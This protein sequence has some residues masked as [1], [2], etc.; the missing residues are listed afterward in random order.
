MSRYQLKDKCM[1]VDAYVYDEQNRKPGAK[2]PDAIPSPHILDQRT[3]PA[4]SL[5]LN[6][7]AAFITR[8]IVLG[9]D[10]D[11]IPQILQ[12]EYPGAG[13]IFA[14]EVNTVY[15]MLAP[16][17]DKRSYQRAH[18]A[19]QAIGSAATYQGIS[20]KKGYDLDFRV[21]WFPIGGYKLPL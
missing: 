15:T 21:N 13:A 18:Q 10:T 7:T 20:G 3:D 12:S 11:L 8:F 17:L 5:K 16:Y 14:N 19:P 2:K 4:T 1:F 9:V 6:D